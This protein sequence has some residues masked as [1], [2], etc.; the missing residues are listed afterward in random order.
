[1]DE[2]KKE[3][4]IVDNAELITDTEETSN[5]KVEEEKAD[6][7]DE[8]IKALETDLAST[9][10][11][12]YRKAAEFDNTKKRLE[13]E[14]EE[15]LKYSNEKIILKVLEF[16]DNLERAVQSSVSA[17]DFDAMLKGV[18]MTLDHLK[19]LLEVEGVKALD[20]VGKD[21][22]PY[23]HHAVMTEETDEHKENTVMLEL[24]KGYKMKD[25]I[26]RP[27]LVKVAKK[28]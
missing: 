9:K 26:I 20:A 15:F 25:R 1:M 12:Y 2:T 22:N 18:E 28:K 5:E 16:V 17:K 19:H 7:R 11:Q 27:S 6:P 14:K 24:Q 10:E 8:K 3:E 21:F 23:E 4:V 13:K